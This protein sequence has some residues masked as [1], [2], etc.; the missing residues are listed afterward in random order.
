MEA[1]DLI[2]EQQKPFKQWN[3]INDAM[4]IYREAEK[5][6][7]VSEPETEVKQVI[8]LKK[9]RLYYLIERQKEVPSKKW[10]Q[11][12]TNQFIIGTSISVIAILLTLL[13]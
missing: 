10:Y 11:N 9:A 2:K 8:D 6:M 4:K 3:A 1:E 7:N 13:W 5:H 12:T